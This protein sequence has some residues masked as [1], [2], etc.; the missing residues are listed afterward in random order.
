[1][2]EENKATDTANDGA[3]KSHFGFKDIDADQKQDM[4]KGVFE[5]VASK[6]DIMNDF[7]SGGLH[8]LWKASLIDSINPKPHMSLI[9]VAGGTGDIS[10]RFIEKIKKQGGK[11]KQVTVC[12]INQAMLDVG[13]DRA[14]DKGLLSEVNWVC[15]NAEE[16]PFADNSFDVYTIAFGIRNVTHIDRALAEAKR[17]LKPGGHFLCLEFSTP[18][19]EALRKIYNWYSFNV[20]PELGGMVADDKPS[21]QY[22]VESIRRFPKQKAFL[23]MLNDAGFEKT[24]YRNMSGGIVAIHS[25][26]RL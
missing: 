25:G 1:M 14:I 16:L 19:Q 22:L 2:S 11:P 26:W 12:D 24:S 7:M 21:Y 23:E 10:F 5:N 9:D 18:D 15:G 8:R 6:Y 13:K 4:V 20:I 3:E 17:V